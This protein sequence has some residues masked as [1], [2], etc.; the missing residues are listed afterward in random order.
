MQTNNIAV[1]GGG[2]AGLTAAI[3]AAMHGADVTIYEGGERCG[4]K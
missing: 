3:S 4:K 1:I 2:A